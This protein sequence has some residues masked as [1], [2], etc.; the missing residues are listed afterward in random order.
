MIEVRKLKSSDAAQRNPAIKYV[1]QLGENRQYFTEKA[2]V[3]LQTK[4][5]TFAIPCVV[6]RFYTEAEIKEVKETE[7]KKGLYFEGY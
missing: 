6:G 1:V 4:L 5:N 7:Y 2:L 3:E